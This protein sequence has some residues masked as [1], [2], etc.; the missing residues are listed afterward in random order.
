MGLIVMALSQRSPHLLYI[1]AMPKV[2]PFPQETAQI[3]VRDLLYLRLPWS[4]VTRRQTAPHTIF[5][6]QIVCPPE[7]T[8]ECQ[9]RLLTFSFW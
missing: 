6:V 9:K 3:D 5:E 7:S 2:H 1:L 4:W 8:C